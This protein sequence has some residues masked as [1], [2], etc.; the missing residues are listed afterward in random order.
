MRNI[1]EIQQKELAADL[2]ISQSKMTR[3]LSERYNFDQ[4]EGLGYLNQMAEVFTSKSY[5][6]VSGTQLYNLS[7]AELAYLLSEE[8]K[9]PPVPILLQPGTH[10][11]FKIGA[12]LLLA[13]LTGYVFWPSSI[14]TV[15]PPI[16]EI[17][18]PADNDTVSTTIHCQ[19][20][21]TPLKEGYH[22]WLVVEV[23]HQ[24]SGIMYWPKKPSRSIVPDEDGNWEADIYE[25]G[26]EPSVKLAL[27]VVH[28]SLDSKIKD[29]LEKCRLVQKYPSFNLLEGA[30]RL[31]RREGLFVKKSIS[32]SR[33]Q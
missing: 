3:I 33:I 7:Y 6:S 12:I 10:S 13:V 28:D 15:W 21:L 17:Q 24:D 9:K 2:G 1:I 16:G 22:P 31:N 29:W 26:M 27:Y 5:G 30:L 32:A 19:G 25:D 4:E 11:Y 14:I 18:S 8:E 20:T 23:F